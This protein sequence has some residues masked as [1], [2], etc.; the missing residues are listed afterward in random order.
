M[1]IS[2]NYQGKKD[3]EKKD[4]LPIGLFILACN[5]IYN[6]VGRPTGET[7]FQPPPPLSA[8][9]KGLLTIAFEPSEE[10]VHVVGNFLYLG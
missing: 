9:F 5:S 2:R 1:Y 7:I 4:R 10:C 8:L 3:P 6:V